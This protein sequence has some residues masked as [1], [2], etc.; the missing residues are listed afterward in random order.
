ML[1]SAYKDIKLLFSNNIE[2]SVNVSFLK[3]YWL[4]IH[5]T[6]LK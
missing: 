5:V 4:L 2:Y 1:K 6:L 3:L